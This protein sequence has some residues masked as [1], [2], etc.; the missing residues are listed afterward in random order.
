MKSGTKV[1]IGSLVIAGAIA[2]GL[3]V[4]SP[5]AVTTGA[6]PPDMCSAPRYYQQLCDG[7]WYATWPGVGPAGHVDFGCS[8]HSWTTFGETGRK[9]NIADQDTGNNPNAHGYP[10]PPAT[11]PAAVHD[12]DRCHTL[13]DLGSTYATACNKTPPGGSQ[14]PVM[15]TLAQV[16]DPAKKASWTI[17]FHCSGVTPIPPTSPPGPTA[18]PGSTP[19]MVCVTVTP[20]AGQ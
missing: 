9:F 16:T 12:Y 6:P 17:Q 1:G 18:P 13:H 3:K 20:R 10:K 7:A 19:A 15:K 14:N 5:N 4:L 8:A 11:D 2:V